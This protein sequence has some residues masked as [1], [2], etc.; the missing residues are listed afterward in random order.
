MTNSNEA[1]KKA[2]DKV[3]DKTEES[4]AGI[5]KKVG[6]DAKDKTSETIS[7]AGETIQKATETAKNFVSDKA[8]QIG[9]Y[10]QQTYD[11]ANQ[12]GG[13]A[14]EAISSSA[15]YV[16]NIDV[17]KARDTVKTAVKEKPELSI[18]IA[19]LT[20]LVIGLVIGRT[21]KD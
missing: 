3:D 20:G 16:K 5:Q 2:A 1:T 4:T 6:D 12:L 14:A 9:T 8:G 11:K 19:A 13:R 7:A 10:A 15:D 17:E 18:V 21:R